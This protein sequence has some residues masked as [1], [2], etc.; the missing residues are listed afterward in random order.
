MSSAMLQEHA[1][2]QT[3]NYQAIDKKVVHHND[4]QFDR[5]RCRKTGGAI[6]HC[7]NP[8]AG[9]ASLMKIMGRF[10]WNQQSSLVIAQGYQINE[11]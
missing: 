8:A 3:G 10:R 7:L 4:Q 11:L 5:N 2:M 1:S 9:T 6:L